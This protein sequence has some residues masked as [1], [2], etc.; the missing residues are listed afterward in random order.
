MRPNV[1][2]FKINKNTLQYVG[3]DTYFQQ[4]IFCSPI[5]QSVIYK[6]SIKVVKSYRNSIYIGIVDY[7]KRR[8]QNSAYKSGDAICYGG[9][10]VKY[11]AGKKEG[12]GFKPN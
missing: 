1:D 2:S 12:I 4:F 3:S 5:P 10:G 11:P 7:V 8:E 9:D 6:F